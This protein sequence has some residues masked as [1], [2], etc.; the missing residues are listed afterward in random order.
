MAPKTH[1][2]K[3]HTSPKGTEHK[4]SFRLG[5]AGPHKDIASGFWWGYGDEFFKR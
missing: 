1:E 2:L 4:C 3:I 5:H